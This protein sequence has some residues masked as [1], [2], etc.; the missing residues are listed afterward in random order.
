MEPSLASQRKKRL[1]SIL[2]VTINIVVVVFALVAIGVLVK[3]K[4]P[5]AGVI[6]RSLS[7]CPYVVLVGPA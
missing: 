3:K 1:K 4:L 5:G 2:D 6:L 7:N